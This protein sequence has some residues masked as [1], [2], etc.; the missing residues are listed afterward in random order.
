MLLLSLTT[1]SLSKIL[2]I[3][4]KKRN[5]S[6]GDLGVFLGRQGMTKENNSFS[7]VLE[8]LNVANGKKCNS[9]FYVGVASELF[10][11]SAKQ[12]SCVFLHVKLQA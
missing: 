7:I 8:Q 6:S 11:E 4:R 12:N 3:C 10:K 1:L 5:I 9:V 2:L